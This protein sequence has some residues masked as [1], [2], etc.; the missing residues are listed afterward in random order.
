DELRWYVWDTGTA[1]T[2]WS[3]RLAV[4]DDEAGCAWALAATDRR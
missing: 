3:L 4:E 1:D 2:G